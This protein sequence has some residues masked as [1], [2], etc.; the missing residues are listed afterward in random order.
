MRKS[1]V[2]TLALVLAIAIWLTSLVLFLQLSQYDPYSWAFPGQESD[3]SRILYL[4]RRA[5]YVTVGISSFIAACVLGMLKFVV[6]RRRR[7]LSASA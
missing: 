7:R 3:I 6:W 4:E 1:S 5:L 2:L